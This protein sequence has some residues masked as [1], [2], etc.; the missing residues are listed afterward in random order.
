MTTTTKIYQANFNI[1]DAPLH[2]TVSIAD[3]RALVWLPGVPNGLLLE[4][5]SR[6]DFRINGSGQLAQ[7]DVDRAAS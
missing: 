6:V 5:G 1:N 2:F 3:G 4:D 7:L